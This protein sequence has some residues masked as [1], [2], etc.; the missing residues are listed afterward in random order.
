VNTTGYS[1]GTCSAG[2]AGCV[3]GTPT[4]SYQTNFGVVNNA[5]NIIAY[6]PRQVQLGIRL[7]F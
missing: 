1:I 2:Q 6:T 3:T 4:L 7:H 5:N